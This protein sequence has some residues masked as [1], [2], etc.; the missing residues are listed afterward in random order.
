MFARLLNMS[1]FTR[2]YG[3]IS[4]T[5]ESLGLARLGITNPTTIY[6]NL[7]YPTLLEHEIENEEGTL[8]KCKYGDTFSIDTGKFTGRSP[9]DG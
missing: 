3:G 8:M 9:N 5:C 2:N 4:T 1:R 7:P 6:R